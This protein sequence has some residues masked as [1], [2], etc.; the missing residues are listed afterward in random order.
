M[1]FLLS[2]NY[3]SL[4]SGTVA[5]STPKKQGKDNPGEEG[6]FTKEKTGPIVALRRPPQ[7]PPVLGPLVA[8]SLSETCSGRDSNDE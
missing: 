3:L 6:T 5:I 1:H 2:E 8:L 7:L 4:K